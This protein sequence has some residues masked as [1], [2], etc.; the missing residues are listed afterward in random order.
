MAQ[1]FAEAT[2]HLLLPRHDH[3]TY[4][5]AEKAEMLID[6]YEDTPKCTY[7]LLLCRMDPE[8]IP[9]SRRDSVR[10]QSC[11]DLPLFWYRYLRIDQ[12]LL[13]HLT[14]Q[15]S[16]CYLVSRSCP[17]DPVKF[18]QSWFSDHSLKTLSSQARRLSLDRK[19]SAQSD[20]MD[21][22]SYRRRHL[23]D[24]CFLAFHWE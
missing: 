3:S 15:V 14:Y 19:Q 7:P 2:R 12:L 5:P 17:T 13:C 4:T 22:L 10:C 16:P 20:R 6:P 23:F 21:T 24:H 11:L 9:F 18:D 1:V 8:L